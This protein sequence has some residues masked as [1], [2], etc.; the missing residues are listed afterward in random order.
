VVLYDCDRT[1]DRLGRLVEETCTREGVAQTMGYT[2]DDAGRLTEVHEDGELRHRY[3]YARGG[4]RLLV[5][6]LA[7]ETTL[8]A[9]YDGQDRHARV[10]DATYSWTV[11]GDLA[12]RTDQGGTTHYTYDT[13][14]RLAEVELPDTTAITYEH[15]VFGRRAGKLVDGQ[16]VQRWL[17]SGGAAPVAE[18][19]A[20]GVLTTRFVYAGGG[21]APAYMV[22]DG[23]RYRYIKDVRGSPILL[24][25]V[26]SGEVAQRLV[27]SPWGEVL[28]D[29]NPGFQPFGFTGGLYDPDTGLVRLGARDYDPAAGRWTQRDPIGFAGGDT[30][31]YAYVGGD[32]INLTDTSGLIAD[33]AADV[34]FVAYDIYDIIRDLQN[35]CDNLGTNL[36]AL[37]LDLG[38]ALIPFVTGGGLALRAAARVGDD[39]VA[40]GSKALR[41]ADNLGAPA[42]KQCRGGRCPVGSG[43][44]FVGGTP[45]LTER[46]LQPIEDVEVGDR[47]PCRR[48]GLD[49]GDWCEVTDTI[50]RTARTHLHLTIATDDGTEVLEVTG[51]HPFWVAGTG[52]A[53]AA[54][55]GVG[56]ELELVVGGVAIVTD[57]VEDAEATPV[58]NFTTE[59]HHTYSV[60][61]SGAWVHNACNAPN[62]RLPRS[63]GRWEGTPGDGKWFSDRDEVL[64]I[65]GADPVV[66][67]GG[68]PDFSSWSKGTVEFEAGVL[69]GGSGD[70]SAVYSKLATELGLKNKTA[71]KSWLKTKG[72]T[73]HH[74][75]ATTILLIPT[76]LHKNIPHIGAA[77]DLR[78]AQ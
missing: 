34:A 8:T 2:Y 39:A 19:D 3:A 11:D 38:G 9:E 62:G 55:L 20:E 4:S 37:G 56:D 16:V 15:D 10:G 47:V 59:P 43:L 24:V 31:L 61:V 66:F 5:E 45:V 25:D 70:F 35:G 30:N 17:Y 42:A 29:S 23:R 6:D 72:L 44:C 41:S 74:Q 50:Q 69:T 57:L 73:P 32:P 53:L 51:E 36:A 64:G 63:R 26:E 7:A 22:R 12:T 54:E 78:V 48:E 1:R 52:W 68:R 75:D 65:T 33:T 40:V 77:S 21:A 27:Y 14:G 13:L 18:Y 49:L 46:G 76:N 67:A 28:E 60:G 58:Y 71:A